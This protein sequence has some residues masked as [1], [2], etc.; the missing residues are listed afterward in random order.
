MDEFLYHDVQHARK[1]VQS[2]TMQ[3]DDLAVNH[4]VYWRIQMKLHAADF[5]DLG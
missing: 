3:G 1:H 2:L 5:T 4:D